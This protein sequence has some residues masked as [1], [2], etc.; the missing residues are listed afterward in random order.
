MQNYTLPYNMSVK[1]DLAEAGKRE[2]CE[3]GAR[4]LARSGHDRPEEYSKEKYRVV[5]T[6]VTRTRDSAIAYDFHEFQSDDAVLCVC[7]LLADIFLLN[8][9]ATSF[10]ANAK[11]VE[12]IEYP[13]DKVAVATS[14]KICSLW[15]DRHG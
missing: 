8:R 2:L 14:I 7:L 5:H 3:L 1:A 10:F 4:S 13:K 6:H 11:A 15:I 12:Y 9:F